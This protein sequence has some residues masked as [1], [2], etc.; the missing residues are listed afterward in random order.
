MVF[1]EF[2]ISGSLRFPLLIFE[3]IS[4]IIYLE[5]SF[6]FFLKYKQK[7]GIIK[8]NSD[9]GFAFFYLGF[10]VMK[11]LIIIGNYYLTDDVQTPF[12]IWNTGSD[13]SLIISSGNFFMMVMV[14]TF[15]FLVEKAKKVLYKKYLFTFVS[16]IWI[17]V[18]I[19]LFFFNLD[20]ALVFAILFNIYFYTVLIFYFLDV[21][22]R[23]KKRRIILLG[24]SMFIISVIF[25][26]VGIF[27]S[28]DVMITT[29]G[30]EV[31][32]YGSIFQFISLVILF[33]F[34]FK[35]PSYSEV[36][37]KQN[38]E[39]IF[40]MNR[41]GLTLF[42]QSFI[43]SKTPSE[44]SQYLISGAITSADLFI[45]EITNSKQQGLS[46]FK[47]GGNVIYI[48]TSDLIILVLICNKEIENVISYL[49]EFTDRIETIYLN[50]L[51]NFDGDL[52]IFNPVE[53]IVKEV[54]NM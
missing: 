42:H 21:M 27:L 23:I 41:G 12:Y 25:F 11:V 1:T 38:I 7:K 35:V 50:V 47:K 24:R 19:F 36:D 22:K 49:K 52:S 15:L 54:F 34:F 2:P 3:W 9:L 48:Y 37:F 16:L 43:E 29:Y 26:I 10:S 51:L 46:S 17:G 30:L 6:I 20:W 53:N 33:F 45:K 13:R 44:S 5:F 32:I 31:K 28:M 8:E 40:L 39:E 18:F 14:I 4:L